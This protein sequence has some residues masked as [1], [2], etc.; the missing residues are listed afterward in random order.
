MSV[1]FPDFLSWSESEMEEPSFSEFSYRNASSRAYYALF[2]AAKQRLKAM[3][4]QVVPVPRGG[5]HEAVI[6]ALSNISGLGREIA[7][8][9]RRIKRFRHLC[10]YDIGEDVNH[11]RAHQ[12]VIQVRRLIDRLG[13]L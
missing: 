10:D 12:Q 6:C 13:R 3:N 4:V 7:D 11:R 2:H 5:S 1:D 9:M 8:D